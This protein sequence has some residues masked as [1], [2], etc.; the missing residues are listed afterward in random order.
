VT[1]LGVEPT[2]AAVQPGHDSEDE[3]E[4]AAIE[5]GSAV[6]STHV[7][8]AKDDPQS[9]EVVLSFECPH[10][11]KAYDNEQS[12]KVNQHLIPYLKAY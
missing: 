1:E 12:L 10:C 5:S 8:P 9:G 4:E 7:T 2:Q 6:I 11:D 3:V